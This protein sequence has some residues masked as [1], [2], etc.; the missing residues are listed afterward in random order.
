MTEMSQTENRII[1][2][3]EKIPLGKTGLFG[4]QHFIALISGGAVVPALLMGLDPSI[5]LMCSGIGT[6]LFLLVTKGK[7][8]AYMGV[9]FSLI[10]PVVVV[11]A[12]SG[13]NAALGGIVACGLVFIVVGL[14]IKITGTGWLDRIFPPVVVGSVIIVIGVGLSPDAINMVFTGAEGE[15]DGSVFFVGIVTLIACVVFSSIKGFIGTVSILLGIIVGYAVSI[16]FGLVDFSGVISA[17]WIGLPSVTFPSFNLSAVL[18]IAPIAFVVI[19]DHIGKML[20]IGGMTD[21]DRIATLPQSLVG[22]GLATVAAGAFGGPAMTPIAETLGVMTAT[23]VYA[24]RPLWVAAVLS[25]IA[26]GFCPKLSQLILS[27]PDPVLGGVSLLLF[28]TISINGVR[29]L[30]DHRVDFNDNK[31]VMVASVT[32]IVGIGMMTAGMVVPI[33]GFSIPG[34]LLATVLAILL[35]LLVP[36]SVP[37]KADGPESEP[38]ALEES[39]AEK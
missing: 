33:G 20:L 14:I 1:G 27:I 15:F 22:N 8:P 21:R 29:M 12:A 35:N 31:N 23:R 7:I 2:P 30:V 28:G 39:T 17:S 34:L 3:E 19:V 36:S 11:T 9:S 5:T 24:V 16:P 10:S 13:V 32:L 37:A 18:T 4:V 26:G 25:V 6:L 38:A